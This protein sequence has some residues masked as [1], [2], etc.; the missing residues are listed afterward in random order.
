MRQAISGVKVNLEREH[1]KE[2]NRPAAGKEKYV[3]E[4]YICS[5]ACTLQQT[6]L[7]S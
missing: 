5:R 3:T 4:K 7:K 1:R 6:Q 2:K